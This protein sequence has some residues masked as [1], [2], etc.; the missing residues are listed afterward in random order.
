MGLNCQISAKFQ[1]WHLFF[2]IQVHKKVPL[3]K[4]FLSNRSIVNDNGNVLQ[5]TLVGRIFF[6]RVYNL[7]Q[8]L[9]NLLFDYLGHRIFLYSNCNIR[10]C[11]C[12]HICK[13]CL[14][15]Y[16]TSTAGWLCTVNFHFICLFLGSL[17][18][19]CQWR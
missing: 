7:L 3:Q 18:K 9:P 5:K 2:C 14:D 6:Q 11:Y 16:I 15:R 10:Y 12:G 13:H 19:F 8:S 4:D 1:D 17:N